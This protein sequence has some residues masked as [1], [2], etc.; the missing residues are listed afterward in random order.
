MLRV[1][2]VYSCKLGKK[3]MK[4]KERKIIG[5]IIETLR[6]RI[7]PIVFQVLE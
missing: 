1:I 2:C 5:S 4:R 3:K 7:S 6:K